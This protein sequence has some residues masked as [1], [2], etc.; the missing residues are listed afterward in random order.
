V[1]SMALKGPVRRRQVSK[2]PGLAER[3]HGDSQEACIVLRGKRPL[4]YLA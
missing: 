2:T 1:S 4:T 3:C